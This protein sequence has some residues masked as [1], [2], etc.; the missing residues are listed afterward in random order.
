MEGENSV[1]E[2]SKPMWKSFCDHKY[3]D[4][5]VVA[6]GKQMF[7]KY[8]YA[9]LADGAVKGDVVAEGEEKEKKP[10]MV[11]YILYRH[12]GGAAGASSDDETRLLGFKAWMPVG[13]LLSTADQAVVDHA[14]RNPAD[15]LSYKI[16]YTHWPSEK[17]ARAGDA[18]TGAPTLL[19][20]DA[21]VGVHPLLQP[22]LPVVV[23]NLSLQP[24]PLTLAS[25]AAPAA[26][27]SAKTMVVQRVAIRILYTYP[28]DGS[29]SGAGAVAAPRRLRGFT[30]TI[31]AGKLLSEAD[32]YVLTL[33]RSKG[34]VGEGRYKVSYMWWPSEQDAQ[35]NDFLCCKPEPQLLPSDARVG[36]H[37]LLKSGSPGAVPVVEVS[38]H[39]T[40]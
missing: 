29:G 18:S 1:I 16:S 31:A 21:R 15:H 3:A 40:E 2:C 8:P 24:A 35:K 4:F 34:V 36:E 32:Q 9:G 26:S 7:S 6:G 33:A 11:V 20:P 12:L 27:S 30:A 38:L 25:S 19:P 5:L 14:V 10:K 37:P 22:D 17:A 13:D 39:K 23:A 28:H